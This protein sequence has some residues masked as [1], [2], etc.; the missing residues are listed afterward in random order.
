MVVGFENIH[1]VAIKRFVRRLNNKIRLQR[2]N[3]TI[4]LENKSCFLQTKQKDGFQVLL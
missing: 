4:F 3:N 1:S 2:F